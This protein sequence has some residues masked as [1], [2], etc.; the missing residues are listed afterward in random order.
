VGIRPKNC[1]KSTHLLGI[2]GPRR[3]QDK[4][5]GML[6]FAL[7]TAAASPQRS[8]GYSEGPARR[9]RERPK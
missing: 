9:R 5:L 1:V 6:I 4:V 2:H 3:K 8:K 7:G